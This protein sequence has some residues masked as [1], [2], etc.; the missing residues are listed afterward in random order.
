MSTRL[1][2]KIYDSNQI[3][4]YHDTAGKL[5]ACY[6]PDIPI[7]DSIHQDLEEIPFTRVEY[8]S[9]YG[10]RNRT[11][12]KTWAFGKV[13]SDIVT[14][15]K[16]GQSLSFKAEPM[17]PFLQKLGDYCRKVS[18]Y[19]WDFDPK[20]NTCI[21]GRYDNKDDSIGFHFDTETFLAHHFCANVTIGY[22]RDF[23]FRDESRR[24]H[25]VALKDKSLF[26]FN[27]LEHALPKRASVKKG[28]VRYSISFR[29]MKNDIGIANSYYYCRGLDGAI[30]D[31]NKKGYKEKLESL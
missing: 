29:N 17:P 15:T 18:V 14:Y 25:Q 3:F 5:R 4:Q 24:I 10:R 21:I 19:N 20:Y 27:G 26:F 23:Q 31:I 22:S 9:R 2:K 30:E 7:S 28:E 11:P 12:R 6:F 13:E 1:Q 16:Y 8:I